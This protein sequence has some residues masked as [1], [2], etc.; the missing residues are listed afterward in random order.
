METSTMVWIWEGKVKKE[1]VA[2]LTKPTK[3]KVKTFPCNDT[4]RCRPRLM[5]MERHPR[6]KVKTTGYTDNL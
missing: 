1:T 2:Y 5:I 6:Q 4:E 3:I